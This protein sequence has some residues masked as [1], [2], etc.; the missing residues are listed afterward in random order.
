MRVPN[1]NNNKI[2]DSYGTPGITHSVRINTDISS[3]DKIHDDSRRDRLIVTTGKYNLSVYKVV[4]TD[5]QDSTTIKHASFIKKQEK[6]ALNEIILMKDLLHNDVFNSNSSVSLN[7]SFNTGNMSNVDLYNSYLSVSIPKD[8]KNHSNTAN[9]SVSPQGSFKLLNHNNSINTG[10]TSSGSSPSIHL[11]NPHLTLQASRNN[12]TNSIKTKTISTNSDVKT[13]YLAHNNIIAVTNTSTTVSLYDINRMEKNSIF[14]V[15]QEHT[16]TI[17]SID[18]HPLQSHSL[19]AGDMNGLV[20]LYD[21]RKIRSSSTLPLKNVSDLTITTKQNDAIRDI[22]WNP[23]SNYSF[24]TVHDSGSILKYDIRYPSQPE[25]KISAHDGPGLCIHWMYEGTDYLASGGRDGKLC[26][27]YMG[28]SRPSLGMPEVSINVGSSIDKLK[29]RPKSKHDKHDTFQ[30]QSGY[31]MNNHEVAISCPKDQSKNNIII[32]KP[33]QMYMPLKVIG[34]QRST[35]GF[36]W[37][38]ENNLFSIDKGNCINGFD[39]NKEPEMKNNLGGK[40]MKWRDIQGDGLVFASPIGVKERYEEVETFLD[41]AEE[42]NIEDQDEYNNEVPSQLISTTPNNAT[43]T[44]SFGNNSFK[45]S[46]SKSPVMSSSNISFVQRQRNNLLLKEKKRMSTGSP[47]RENFFLANS[48]NGK[49][50]NSHNTF[51]MNLKKN[52]N[53]KMANSVDKTGSSD[54]SPFHQLMKSHNNWTSITS[55]NSI[56]SNNT[57][58]RLS[59]N[60]HVSKTNSF[61]NLSM[62]GASKKQENVIYSLS[63]PLIYD[64]LVNLEEGEKKTEW[65]VKMNEN[66]LKL[67]FDPV[68]RFKYLSRNLAYANVNYDRGEKQIKDK[69]SDYIDYEKAERERIIQNLGFH[70]DWLATTED[71]CIASTLDNTKEVQKTSV[72]KKKVDDNVTKPN[73]RI[74]K[75]D[76]E[77][78]K[79]MCSHNSKIYEELKDLSKAKLWNMIGKGINYQL[80]L[81]IKREMEEETKEDNGS[82]DVDTPRGDHDYDDNVAIVES[83]ID[84]QSDY[85]LESTSSLSKASS[86]ISSLKQRTSSLP[87][88]S[89]SIIPLKYDPALNEKKKSFVKDTVKIQK[90]QNLEDVLTFDTPESLCLDHSSKPWSL[91]NLVTSIHLHS[92]KM[93]DLLTSSLIVLNFHQ[94]LS[95]S[96]NKTCDVR[97]SVHDFIEVLHTYE[98]FD[99]SADLLKGCSLAKDILNNSNRNE[100]DAESTENS[101]MIIPDYNNSDHVCCYCESKVLKNTVML[102]GC[103]HIGHT[104]CMKTWFGTSLN[105][106]LCP[107]G[108][109]GKLI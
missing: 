1:G 36:V 99:V 97:T 106:C 22:K 73:I 33:S 77:K 90:D 61:N 37:F 51:L 9:M 102:L 86:F 27:W 75:E 69:E 12:S 52:G 19:L 80:D 23:N 44:S 46:F 41:E 70:D 48:E 74:Y 34:T 63:L 62:M 76:Y 13:G 58:G 95:Y 92:L 20:K 64:T 31:L 50:N 100:G 10:L 38:D 82:R 93:G 11:H 25:K 43:I 35:T 29:F 18:F 68:R 59:T 49:C 88:S 5:I 45:N 53:K 104:E 103:G 7:T 85:E 56:D 84:M 3:I 47:S 54:E 94:I 107:F 101:A 6:K 83:D 4:D 57:N 66:I 39:L 81:L 89:H 21:L 78:L 8:T 40:G 55:H 28:D 26:Y 2:Y 14:G 17:N 32:Y 72:V 67:R 65:S 71:K 60:S 98:L 16:R 96:I 30:T 15:I 24:A 108:C 79:R 87:Q 91:C 42:A 109:I 105:A